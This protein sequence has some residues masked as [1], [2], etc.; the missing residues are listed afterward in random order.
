MSKPAQR[1]IKIKFD[2]SENLLSMMKRFAGQGIPVLPIHGVV[3]NCCTCGDAECASPGKHPISSL[4]PH[5]VKDAKTNMRTIRRWHRKYPDMNYAVAT[6]GLAVIDCDSKEA[7]RAFRSGCHPPPT[8]TVKTARGFH[9]YYR[10]EMPPRIGVRNKLDV[11]SGPGSYVVGPGARHASGSIYAVWEDDPIADLPQNIAGITEHTDEPAGEVGGPIPVGMRNSTLTQFAGYMHARNVPKEALLDALKALNRSM[12]E[13]PLPDRE[14]RQIARSV[15]R[16]PTKPIPEMLSFA[17]IPDE[18]L[19]WLWFP[20]LSFRT[21]ALLDGNPGEG[22]S[23]FTTWLCARVSRGDLLPNGDP[24]EPANC[25]L[26]NFEDLPGAVIK[27]RLEANGANLSRVFVQSRPFRLTPEM[28]Q[29]LEGE[30]ISKKARLVILDPIQAVITKGTDTNSNVDVRDFM[31]QLREIAERNDCSIICIRHFGK[32]SHEKAMMKGIGSTD[33]VGIARNQLGLGRRK[34]GERG[35]LTVTLKANY[36]EAEG[37]LFK[38]T[39]ADARAGEQPSVSFD[40]FETVDADEFFGSG[41][42]KRGPEQDEREVAKGYL[43]DALADGPK[44][45]TKLKSQGEARA[46]SASTLDRARKELGII[47]TK[48]GK[49]W[50]WSLAPE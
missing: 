29:W 22:K 42:A 38:M 2:R 32:G 47:T 3:D 26:C 46:I 41:N 13:K 4:V 8:F 36:N 30:I 49:I 16:Y 45:A 35:F 28:A 15:S 9:F 48:E 37:A 21:L 25:F 43:L 10:G 33:F 44:P 39:T 7:L 5:G 14:V 17:D 23:Q 31:D 1:N 6:E 19:E 24:M 34:D 50:F 12:S 40:R 27:K 18:K 11:K 20:F